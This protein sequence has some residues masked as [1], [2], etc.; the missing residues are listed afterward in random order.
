MTQTGFK[1]IVLHFI[2]IKL[3]L[4]HYDYPRLSNNEFLYPVAV[5]VWMEWT[6]QRFKSTENT[7]FLFNSRKIPSLLLKV[8]AWWYQHSML[9]L[10]CETNLKFPHTLSPVLVYVCETDSFNLIY[11][12]NWKHIQ[13]VHSSPFISSKC[14]C[15]LLLAFNWKNI[16]K[17]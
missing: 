6:Y 7:E 3:L 17:K 15:S 4:P 16:I 5:H 12:I 1:E 13:C 9:K 10:F 11:L 2:F 8:Q 14:Y